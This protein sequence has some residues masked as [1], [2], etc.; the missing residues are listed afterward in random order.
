MYEPASFQGSGRQSG[1]FE[2]WYFKLV[3]PA[4]V[5]PIAIIPGVSLTRN[6]A[7][8][9]IQI[10]DGGSHQSAYHRFPVTD[11]KADPKKFDLR[12]GP[13][14][15]SGA[16]FALD[17]PG[18]KGAVTFGRLQPWPVSLF[19]PG[20]M[21]PFAF[22]PRMECQ[23]GIISFDHSLT[24]QLT[25]GGSKENY[26][27]GRGYIEK[28]WGH[29]MPKAW[30]WLQSNDFAPE[31]TSLSVSVARVPWL[32]MSFNG[33]IVGFRHGGKLYRFTTYLGSRLK[34][35]TYQPNG[36]TLTF[37]DKDYV[38]DIGAVGGAAGGTELAAP[39]VGAMEGRIFEH[40]PATVRVR[41]YAKVK[42]GRAEIFAGTG[43]F[44][45]LE[46]VGSLVRRG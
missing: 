26:T 46:I 2:G 25:V 5:R 7:H 8:S 35:L 10:L 28:D 30:V 11:F 45:G 14:H 4:G 31:G 29:S 12:V 23:H 42:N 3:D 41:L 36:V 38:L 15:F 13:N 32:G 22:V 21:G 18:I 24:G 16:G 19:S 20:A 1:Y 44:A 39:V 37:E 33:F 43:R 9:F 6:D 27:G 34:E 17:L 40:L